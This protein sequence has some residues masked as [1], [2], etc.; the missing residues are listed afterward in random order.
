M[1][2]QV[3]YYYYTTVLLLFSLLHGMNTGEK[4]AGR[5]DFGVHHQLGRGRGEIQE[6]TETEN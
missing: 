3:L 4:V 6:P 1:A 5:K 2:Y